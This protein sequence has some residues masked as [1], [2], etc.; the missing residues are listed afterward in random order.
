[1]GKKG[2]GYRAPELPPANLLEKLNISEEKL[3]EISQE[4]K[5]KHL[6]PRLLQTAMAIVTGR[7]RISARHVY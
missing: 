2:S 6:A 5:F 7:S 3:K 1:L 4:P